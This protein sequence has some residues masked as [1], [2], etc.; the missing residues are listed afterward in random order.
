MLSI[1]EPGLSS[2]KLVFHFKFLYSLK[3]GGHILQNSMID[4]IWY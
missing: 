2:N 3:R 1:F 4:E